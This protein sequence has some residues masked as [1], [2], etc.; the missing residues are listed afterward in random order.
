MCAGL[1]LVVL[2]CGAFPEQLRG[3]GGPENLAVVVNADSWV[4]QTIAH[5]YLHLRGI[6]AVNVVYLRDLRDWET[7][8]VES[9]RQQ[10]L[11][12]V[13]KTLYDRD[14]L[15][16]I[17]CIAYSADIP[18]AVNVKSDVEDVK[19]EQYQTPVA[20][21]NGLTYLYQ[22]VLA[23]R[24]E[25]LQLD[26]N[27][28]MRRPVADVCSIPATREGQI[29]WRQS[30][31]LMAAGQW[32][33]AAE[34]LRTLAAGAPDG[35]ELHFQLSR[36]LARLNQPEEALA[37]LQSAVR[38]GWA[39]RKLAEADNDLATLHELPVFRE[40]L[41]RMEENASRPFDV[42]PT[43]AFRSQYRW[44]VRGEH[45]REAGPQY[46]LSTVLAVTGGR[47]NS[48]AE[49]RAAL[50]RSV[51]ADGSC[52]PGT[53]YYM[54]NGDVR[55]RTRQPGFQSAVAALEKT[56]VAARVLA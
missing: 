33:R 45:I 36:C 29:A 40:L 19:L 28:Y 4:S 52:P 27:Y 37:A 2:M 23:K 26:V 46:M 3:G 6:P 15:A 41:G 21:I 18:T 17:D 13:L 11:L 44:N 30:L 50:R 49:A 51:A 9:F 22:L 5:E 35:A 12:P 31:Q 10:I 53:I 42:Q 48:I 56:K 14:V 55:A 7:M 32:E 38:A 20:A 54:E 8:D 34:L 47:G 16:H 25:Y 39:D 43:T 24:P 1:F